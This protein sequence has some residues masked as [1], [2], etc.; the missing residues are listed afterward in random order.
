MGGTLP[1]LLRGMTPYQFT[2]S[3][4]IGQ[5]VSRLYW[6]N[7]L[8]AVVGTISAG[9]FLLPG[10]GLRLS[11]T[12]AVLLNAVAGGIALRLSR[13]FEKASAGSSLNES[14]SSVPSKRN[15]EPASPLAI[16]LLL[17]AF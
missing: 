16:R 10:L 8:G 15:R 12:F 4:E 14:Q 5:R 13:Q 2:G 3:T 9:F 6:V 11:V 1:I 17:A 7:T